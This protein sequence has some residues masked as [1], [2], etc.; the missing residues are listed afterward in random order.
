MHH[1]LISQMQ[2]CG[3]NRGT[4]MSRQRLHLV[5]L[6]N[7]GILI[8]AIAFCLVT[9]VLTSLHII[10]SC[11]QRIPAICWTTV[12]TKECMQTTIERLSCLHV[13][14]SLMCVVIR[15]HALLVD[16]AAAALLR[17]NQCLS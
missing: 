12:C 14:K 16:V 7:E 4:Q 13:D 2:Y 15:L 6:T 10:F 5:H 3:L 9:H 17:Q 11:A 8:T 1:F